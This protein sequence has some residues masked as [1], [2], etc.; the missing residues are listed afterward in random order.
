[1]TALL[2]LSLLLGQ[3]E[4]VARQDSLPDLR[5][6]KTG[7]DWPAFLGPRGDGTSAEKG[8]RW[9]PPVVWQ[10]ALGEG[11]AIGACAKGRW[12]QFD[13]FGAKQRLVCLRSETGEELWRFEYPTDY[14]DLYGYDGGPRCSPVV[15]DDRVYIFGPEGMLHCLK[16]VDGAVVWKKDT[17]ADFNVVQ[18]FFGAGSTPA[19]EGE[20]LIAM[21]GGSPPGS[22]GIQSG[23]V[24]GAGSGIVAFDKRTGEVKYKI[25][26]ELAS[27]SSPRIVTIG[28]RRWGF[29]FARGGLVGFDPSS[30]KV[31]FHFPWRARILES[32]NAS[33][34]VVV[35][36]RVFI[37]ECYGPGGALLKVKPGGAEVVWQDG[38]R[39]DRA[40][41]AHWMTPIH[42][43]GSLYG[44]SGRHTDDAELRCV[45]LATG[46]VKWSRPGLTR[47]SLLLVDGRFIVLGEDGVL[48]VVKATP[49]K[50]VEE[51]VT[52]LRGDDGEP[53]LRYPAW[54]APVLS[55]GLLY[56]RGRDRLICLRLIPE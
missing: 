19:V 13:R 36:D 50:Y 15:D 28:D 38:R 33:N 18:N 25:T 42:V 32:V 40:M 47:A 56:V 7:E 52:V 16:V 6:R 54:A 24:K 30:G 12:F 17:T 8:M 55:H 20:L 44:S 39:R 31:D 22:P 5:T 37:T 4:K 9:P 48:R 43:D 29:V 11:Y 46:A 34:P 27:Y 26:D 21:I 35:D 2:L 1:M 3:S 51:A 53:L 45:E 14:Q 10:R 23:Q 49:E 41:A